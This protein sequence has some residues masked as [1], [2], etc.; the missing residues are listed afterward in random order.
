V[1][2]PLIMRAFIL[3]GGFA[4]RLW[5]LTEKRPKPM[6]PLKGKPIIS[7]LMEGIPEDLPVTV[8]TNA[9]FEKDFRMWMSGLHRQHVHLIVEGTLKDDH[10]L[11]ALGALA[12]WIKA[13]G[14]DDDILVL[15]GDNFLGFSLDHFIEKFRGNPLLA[16]HDIGDLEKAKAFG[17]VLVG[18]DGVMVTGFEE[19]PREPKSTLVSAGCAILPRMTLPI[20][21]EYAAA[22]PDNV[23]GI[24]EELLRRG[25][26]VDCFTFS[27]RWM[28]IGA[29]HSYL[30]AHRSLVG[31]HA[32]IDPSSTMTNC[33]IEGSVTVDAKCHIEGSE[34]KDCMVFTGCDIR[35]CTLRNCVIDEGCI[36][37]NVDLTGKMVR[38]GTRLI[39]E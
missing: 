4:T 9:A 39:V 7:L 25:I 36:L 21:L 10:K 18:S 30:D 38:A 13:E 35:D 20:L 6:L 24:F 16:A 37:K 11:G 22:H 8:S 26:A 28:D 5:P 27:E 19:K 31:D 17:T 15:T 33:R 12:Q 14:I 32:I 29:F 2:L 23:G 34:L 3:A 1:V